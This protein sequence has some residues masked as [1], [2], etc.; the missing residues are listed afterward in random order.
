M[1]LQHKRISS[2][3]ALVLLLLGTA[4]TVVPEYDIDIKDVDTDMSLFEEGLAVPL[5]SSNKIMLGSLLNSSG[6]DLSEFLKTDAEG[7][8]ILTYEGTTSLNE[9]LAE[10]DVEGKSS[11]DG[12]DFS[13]D[14]SYHLGDI[15]PDNFTIPADQFDVS[16]PFS[17]VES[18]DLTVDPVSADLSSLNFTAGLDKY[19][20]VVSDNPD[21][22]L[23]DKIGS[24][25]HSE[26]VQQLAALKTAVALASGADQDKSY[27]IP[28]E[29]LPDVTV[30][31]TKLAV[32]VAPIKLHDDITS[33]RNIQLSSNARMN[34]ALQLTTPFING[35]EI[36]PDVD[37][38]LSSV[39]KLKDISNGIIDL[40][41]LKLNPSND[42]TASKSYPIEGLANSNFEDEISI[43][44]NIVVE[45]TFEINDATTTLRTIND[46]EQMT[47]SLSIS[48]SD[49]T[50]ESARIAVKPISYD[51]SDVV[52]IGG[53]HAFS[54]P[55]D[56]KAIKSVD[57]DQNQPIY[58]HITPANLSRL[59]EK[60]IPY[61]ITLDFPS[62]VD[63]KDAVDGT[64][65]FSGDLA[66]GA[67]NLPIVIQAFHPE[68]TDGSVKVKADVTVHADFMAQ[69]LVVDT[70][71]LPSNSSQDISFAVALDG[72]PVISDVILTTNDIE[73]D[74]EH[75][76][77]FDFT[78]NGAETLGSFVVTPKGSPSLQVLCNV[79]DINGMD[80]VP[81]G[82]G[83]LMQLPD[84]F[85][86][87]ASGLDA[88]VLTFDASQNTLL[89]RNSIPAL[90]NLPIT[91]LKINPTKVG[92]EYKVETSYSVEG[93][94]L[95][96]SADVSHNDL[97]SISGTEFGIQVLIPEIKAESI[98][99]DEQFSFNLD[100]NYDMGFDLKTDGFLK[101]ISE[102][103][104]DEVYFTLDSDFAGLPEMG[105]DRFYVDLVLSL[106]SFIVPSSIPVQGYVV[107]GKLTCPPV[108][109]D[110]LVDITPD[111]NDHV[112]GTMNVKGTISAPGQNISIESLNSDIDVT[113][114]AT[115]ADKDGGIRFSRTSGIFSYDVD[116]STSVALDNMPDML[117]DDS[118]S[119]DLD[120]P[121]ITLSISTNL[122]ILLNGSIEILPVIG[123]E[124]N[125]EGKIVLDNIELPHS[126]TN[127]Q[128][129]TKSIVIC[130][131]ATTA[132]A[133][134]EPLEAD[135]MALL[136]P[137]P[138][139]LKINIK[140]S[141]DETTPSVVET[142]QAYTLDI[143][144]GVT[145]PL[146]FG[147]DFHFSTDTEMDFSSISGYTKYGEFGIKGKAVNDSP[148]NLNVE[149]SLLDPDGEL[150]PQS[151]SSTIAIAGESTSDIEFYLSPIDKSRS[152][153]K[154]RLTIY[155]TAVP[156]VAL[157]ETSSLQLTDLSAVLPEGINI[158]VQG[159]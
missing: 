136:S 17:G 34:V 1:K 157:K 100:E 63:V 77:D 36:V 158:T 64:L 76:G 58:L 14:F 78:V 54:V 35:G 104:L 119:V 131:S 91:S 41:G 159:L 66:G 6:Q 15:D 144:Y 68:V 42:W 127:T 85:V 49:L 62:N 32:E 9:Q 90:I 7:R 96:P 149:M 151:K 11:I 39:F 128:T 55:E 23:A 88:S 79:P 52:T 18:V 134:Y 20:D 75:E 153:S 28:K 3:L 84:V 69:N 73:K 99:L 146:A 21:L 38:D 154:A 8:L 53:D 152:I 135:V 106:P 101:S 125:Q 130:K 117:K 147:K 4:C 120:D 132:P 82:E 108:R 29:L 51:H 25:G 156:G 48:F 40:S 26:T 5:G 142:G 87:D 129:Q 133:G 80:F 83:I 31:Q 137:M 86:F 45:G 30:D 112:G 72:T 71:D 44:A 113:F 118:V 65:T 97:K 102:V 10:L 139:E 155:V 2:P 43:N 47:V 94:I 122:G 60:N 123:G 70:D 98:S 95:I 93:T 109:I 141:V 59:K 143:E 13:K 148:L 16:V 121:Q 126:D 37:L 33:I 27:D 116:Q 74:T 145:A 115:I 124:V 111:E 107:D 46:N 57:M 50:V 81:G 56:V 67:A 114:N 103:I 61:T 105:E 22:R 138:D 150:I 89:I 24:K 19:K 110:K 140:A 12:M 92:E